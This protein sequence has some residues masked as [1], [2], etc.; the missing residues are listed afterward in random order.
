[1]GFRVLLETSR[2]RDINRF[3]Q[4]SGHSGFSPGW[5]LAGY[6]LVG[7]F[8][9]PLNMIFPCL[10]QSPLNE[11]W[12][13]REPTRATR[14]PLMKADWITLGIGVVLWILLVVGIALSGGN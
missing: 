13:M 6:I 14:A 12:R 1:M 11:A 9:A 5:F 7:F 4:D 2:W 10:V 8:C 3:A